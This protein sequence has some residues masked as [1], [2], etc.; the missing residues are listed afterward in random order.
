MIHS[1]IRNNLV[2][3]PG[4]ED[5]IPFN[6]ALESSSVGSALLAVKTGAASLTA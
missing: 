3:F 5:D 2:G 6:E 4:D 1:S